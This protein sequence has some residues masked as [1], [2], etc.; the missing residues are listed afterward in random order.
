MDDVLYGQ[1]H[2]PL[3]GRFVPMHFRV[4]E[5]ANS[6]IGQYWVIFIFIPGAPFIGTVR[7]ALSLEIHLT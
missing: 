2:D 7:N 5:V 6:R 1:G 3:L 4:S